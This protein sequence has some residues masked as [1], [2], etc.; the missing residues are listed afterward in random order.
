[1]SE[2]V[3]CGVTFGGAS[4]RRPHCRPCSERINRAVARWAQSDEP[5]PYE[6]MAA[7]LGMRLDALYQRLCR[8]R[9]KAKA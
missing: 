4:Q 9:K 3:R 6:E 7:E 5:A 1:M 8:V 2:C